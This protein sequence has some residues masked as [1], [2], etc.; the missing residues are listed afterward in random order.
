[1]PA[2]R[3]LCRIHVEVHVGQK[4]GGEED[5]SAYAC[6][7]AY[8]ADGEADGEELCWA[9]ATAVGGVRPPLRLFLLS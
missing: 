1:M 3:W 4:Y 8:E 7:G 5:S 6:S 2:G 9:H